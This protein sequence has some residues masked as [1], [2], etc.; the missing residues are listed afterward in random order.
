MACSLS[1][2]RLPKNQKSPVFTRLVTDVRMFAASSFVDYGSQ[3]QEVAF[4][5]ARLGGPIANC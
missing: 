5:F 4:G 3:R 1:R 2:L